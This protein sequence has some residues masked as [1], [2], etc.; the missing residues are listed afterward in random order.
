[1]HSLLNYFNHLE[2]THHYCT[3][4]ECTALLKTHQL[5]VKISKEENQQET[6]RFKMALKYG[7]QLLNLSTT[8]QKSTNINVRF[9]SKSAQK[10]LQRVTLLRRHK[11]HFATFQNI[12]GKKTKLNDNRPVW[13]GITEFLEL[14]NFHHWRKKSFK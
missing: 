1:M 2:C 6:G 14:K 4:N 7:N 5:K 10:Y 12:L 13:S 11:L 3:F 8:R 9:F